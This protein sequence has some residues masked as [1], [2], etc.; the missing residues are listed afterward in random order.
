MMSLYRCANTR[1][2]FDTRMRDIMSVDSDPF[3]FFLMFRF[4]EDLSKS[5]CK[6]H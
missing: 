3:V 5:L 6:N 1:F 2:Y 4:Q